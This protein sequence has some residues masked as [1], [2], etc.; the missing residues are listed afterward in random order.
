VDLDLT[1]IQ[2]AF[3]DQAR[4]VSI[5]DLAPLAAEIDAQQGFPRRG[6]QRLAQ[7]TLLSVAVPKEWG[8][9][10]GDTVAAALVVEELAS[11]CASTA[12]VVCAQSLVCDSIL[13]FGSEAQKHEWLL[14]LAQGS[15]VGGFALTEEGGSGPASVATVAERQGDGYVL[16]G[17]KSF[18]TNGPVADVLLV[19]A[20]TTAG[21]LDS[22]SAFLVPTGSPGVSAGPVHA[23][24]GLRGAV[25]SAMTFEAVRLPAGALLGPEGGGRQL[26]RSALDGGRISAA[27]M[28]VGVARAAF[29]AATRYVQGRPSRGEPIANHQG[30]QFKL[31]EMSAHID[32]GR[33]LTWR[34]A[35]ARDA[36]AAAST[37]ASMAKLVSSETATRV[38]SNAI[39]VLGGNGCLADYPVERHFRDAKVT[40]IYEGTSEM[41]RLGIASALLKE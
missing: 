40:E 39:S 17:S 6:L 22:L 19:F 38:A 35:A 23:K 41:Q 18:V 30:I 14:P 32:A 1:D 33:L 28:A 15:R 2:Q 7:R 16:R 11:G 13:R 8:G 10:G 29:G 37:Y 5:H 34:A 3:R 12:A 31:A 24:L 36:G 4:D 20:L 21:V 26:L 27:A 9:G 25:S